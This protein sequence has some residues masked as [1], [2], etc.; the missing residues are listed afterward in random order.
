LPLTHSLGQVNTCLQWQSRMLFHYNDETLCWVSHRSGY[1]FVGNIP[2]TVY[3]VIS[4][5]YIS[6]FGAR[7]RERFTD[8]GLRSQ[9]IVVVLGATPL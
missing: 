2:P 9:H 5:A 6:K 8:D 4:I 7:N 3:E 1:A